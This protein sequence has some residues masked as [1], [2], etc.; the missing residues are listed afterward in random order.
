VP[1][2]RKRIAL[3]PAPVVASDSEL[4]TSTQPPS[5]VGN[6]AWPSGKMCHE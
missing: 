3:D 2:L 6:V 5:A 1:S 4:D